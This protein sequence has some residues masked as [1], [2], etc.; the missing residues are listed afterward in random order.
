MKIHA[1]IKD[2][3]YEIR[4]GEG[5]QS[6]KWLCDVALFRLEDETKKL[7]AEPKGLRRENGYY[8]RLEKLVK[9]SLEDDENIW[10]I[11]ADEY[12]ESCVVYDDENDEF[13]GYK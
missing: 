8:V 12:D 1:Y 4:V 3:N 13:D 9:N 7:V 6:L 10:I 5:K 11:L 2:R